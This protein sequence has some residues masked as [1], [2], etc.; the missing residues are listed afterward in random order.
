MMRRA[1]FGLFRF[2]SRLIGGRGLGLHRIQ[3]LVSI[4]KGLSR[5]LITRGPMLA[6]V[7]GCKLWVNTD[8]K[9]VR[10]SLLVYGTHE[11]YQTE[12]LLA[13]AKPGMTF[14]DVGANIGYYSVVLAGIAGATGKIYAFE[15]EPTN[16]GFLCRN[17]DEN[18]FKNI[19]PVAKALFDK[20]GAA[21][22]HIDSQHLGSHALS[23][24]TGDGASCSLNV[25]TITLDTFAD[26]E[27]GGHRVDLI[28]IDAQ[29]AEAHILRGGRRTLTTD[30]PAILL[31]FEPQCLLNLGTQPEELLA[32]I[33]ELGF[34]IQIADDAT[35]SLRCAGGA[36]VLATSS[37]SPLLH[38]LLQPR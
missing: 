20:D 33:E 18:G 6:T 28:K 16:L 26:R 24:Q 7:H 22:L 25:E 36:E 3:F 13:L 32:L 30:K 1:L 29:G 11:A 12:I 34:V 17:I 19:V 23:V 4:H 35:K 2:C 21:A 27:L 37:R 15:P 5:R 38:L 14:L 31:E 8:D 9:T 10:D